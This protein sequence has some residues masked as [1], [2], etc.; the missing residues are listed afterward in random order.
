MAEAVDFLTA[1][2]IDPLVFPEEKRIRILLITL[3]LRERSAILEA[4]CESF[5]AEQLALLK[6]ATTSI[7]CL[8]PELVSDWWK[9]D[10]LSLSASL[11]SDRI[12]QVGLSRALTC[13]DW[14][15][16]SAMTPYQLMS[17]VLGPITP[18]AEV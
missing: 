8:I 4:Q 3:L 5:N 2:C 10:A 13:E 12:V 6:N 16:L 9:Y 7:K 14:N 1:I 17:R 15:E 11:L 18:S